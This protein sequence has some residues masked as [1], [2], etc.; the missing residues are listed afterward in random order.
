MTLGIAHRAGGKAILDLLVEVKP[1]FSPADTVAAFCKTLKRYRVDTVVGDK[2]GGEWPRER[3]SEHDVFYKPCE[4]SKSELYLELL[5]AINSKRCELLDHTRMRRQ[6]LDLERRTARGG[7]DTV[8]HPPRK[9]DDLINAAAGALVRIATA[10]PWVSL[11]IGDDPA[12]CPGD[13]HV[14]PMMQ[15]ARAASPAL[16]PSV[17]APE[18]DY[19]PTCG[20]CH[21]KF[22]DPRSGVWRCK[23][24]MLLI[25]VKERGC[26]H[27][28]PQAKD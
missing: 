16:Q 14:S 5:A 25:D 10:E 11:S 18:A 28:E 27:H 12:P 21:N 24:G 6:L 7:R 9:H 17:K 2:Y 23:T 15:R 3:F 22:R 19:T 1:P 26:D 8:D 20:N 13:R 4:E